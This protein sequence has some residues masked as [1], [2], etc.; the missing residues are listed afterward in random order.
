MKQ[1]KNE[2][3]YEFLSRGIRNIS[4][5]FHNEKKKEKEKE[6]ILQNQLADFLFFFFFFLGGGSEMF[7]YE[8]IHLQ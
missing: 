7:P 2:L 5:Q 6:R 3:T 4:F 1:H 8:K